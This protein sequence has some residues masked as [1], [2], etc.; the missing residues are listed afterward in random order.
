MATLKEAAAEFLSKK[1][2]AVAGVSREKGGSHGGNP[3][4]VR[5]RDRGYEVFAVNP[6]AEEV[7]GDACYPN[8]A[9]IPG[10]VEAVVIATR[11]EVASDVMRDCIE[12]GI[13]HVWLHRGP[14]SGSASDAATELGI[15]NDVTVINGGCPLMH[16]PTSDFGHSM[17]RGVLSLVGRLPR[18]V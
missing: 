6:N 14:G 4:Y 16:A 1:R 5:L 10:G 15:S 3:V 2:I 13:K 12:L 18:D 7:E 11:P 17:M 9:A 8:V